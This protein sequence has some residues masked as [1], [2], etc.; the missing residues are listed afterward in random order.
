MEPYLWWEG[1][2]KTRPPA[3]RG[4]GCGNWVSRS[5][6]EFVLV[7]QPTEEVESVHAGQC[8]RRVASSRDGGRVW[9]LEVERAVRPPA[10]VGR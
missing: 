8:H 6:G 10:V 9:R 1:V 5:G 2:V 4:V 3:S 7:D